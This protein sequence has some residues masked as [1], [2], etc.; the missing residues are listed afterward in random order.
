MLGSE[1]PAPAPAGGGGDEEDFRWTAG[2]VRSGAPVGCKRSTDLLKTGCCCC[3]FCAEMRPGSA[4]PAPGRGISLLVG[5]FSLPCGVSEG[6]C[7]SLAPDT[8]LHPTLHPSTHRPPVPHPARAGRAVAR[9]VRGSGGG[10]DRRRLAGVAVDPLA[11]GLV[12]RR[13]RRRSSLPLRSHPLCPAHGQFR[14]GAPWSAKARLPAAAAA[15]GGGPCLPC[16]SCLLPSGRLRCGCWPAA[17][18]GR[19]PRRPLTRAPNATPSSPPAR[20]HP[21]PHPTQPPT[22]PPVH[23]T[24]RL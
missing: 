13:R 7:P 17:A 11:Q 19:W 2:K 22:P 1:A 10:R 23:P 12:P 21:P 16:V 4:E 8:G 9:T 5:W 3:F 24:A 6:V 15:A 14:T 18:T 20:I